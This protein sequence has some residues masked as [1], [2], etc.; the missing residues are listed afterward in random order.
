MPRFQSKPREIEAE[1]YHGNTP[2]PAGVCKTDHE[3]PTTRSGM[4]HPHVHTAHDQIV[5]LAPGDWV[6]P[7]R[8]GRGHYPC[9]PDI[10]AATYELVTKPTNQQ[11]GKCGKGIDCGCGEASHV[12]CGIASCLTCYPAHAPTKEGPERLNVPFGT[13]GKPGH[14]GCLDS[15]LKCGHDIT[16]ERRRA[17]EEQAK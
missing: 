12:D 1:Q 2:F 5:Y 7:E 11:A 6:I 3:Q 10:F 15:R 9:K 8:D 17:K 13:C 14:R 4:D 16:D